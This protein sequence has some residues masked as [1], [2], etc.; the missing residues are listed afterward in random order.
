MKKKSIVYIVII[1]G[2]ILFGIY[3]TI[4][5]ITAPGKYDRFA[6]CLTSKGI[7]MYGTDWC[8]YCKKQ[9]AMFGKSFKYV[10]Y[11]NCDFEKAKCNAAGVRGYP[12]WV[13][14]G[15]KYHGIRSLTELAMLSNCSL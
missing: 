10:N 6:R 13:I 5:W 4:K 14:E 9:K 11:V 1:I 15:K 12:T 7:T 3:G 2:L 8:P